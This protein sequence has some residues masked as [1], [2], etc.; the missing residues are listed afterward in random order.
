MEVL[1][2]RRRLQEACQ[3]GHLDVVQLLMEKGATDWNWGL[4]CACRGGHVEIVKLMIDNGANNWNWGM[5]E[6]CYGGHLGMV[7]LMIEKGA[8]TWSWGLAGACFGG[9]VDIAAWMIDQGARDLIRFTHLS[10]DQQY[11]VYNQ[12]KKTKSRVLLAT[13]PAIQERIR[14]LC[15]SVL[16]D[17][18]PD[19]LIQFIA[20]Q[21]L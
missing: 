15:F 7:H 3:G 2:H 18:L 4:V 1:D 12:V 9:H 5:G 8:T 19:D 21:Y 6:A 14:L 20:T 11:D 13:L 17:K 10:P 16:S